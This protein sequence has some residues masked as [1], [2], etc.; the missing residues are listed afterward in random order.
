MEEKSFSK[1]LWKRG[2][3]LKL[4]NLT[5]FQKV[6]NA[7]C[8]LKPFNSYISVV[9]CSFFEFVMVSKWCIREWIK[10]ILCC[11]LL[12]QFCCYFFIA[13]TK[14]SLGGGGGTGISL[15]VPP[16]VRLCTKYYFLSKRWLG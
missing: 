14:Q 3:L 5:F 11:E 2:K 10:V 16:S 7:N 13:P 1:T 4:S 12:L 8:I 6:F 15:F 9:I